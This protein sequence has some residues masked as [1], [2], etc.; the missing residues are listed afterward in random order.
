M[1]F[2]QTGI[3]LAVCSIV[4]ERRTTEDDESEET[5]E[6][7]QVD[8]EVSS[9][10]ETMSDGEEHE[11]GWSEEGQDDSYNPV[12]AEDLLTGIKKVSKI[13]AMFRRSPKLWER[14]LARTK[15]ELGKQLGL[16]FQSKTR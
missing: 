11:L 10:D 8:T 4:Y 12:F 5:E 16:K 2:P 14:L 7:E 6:Q 15:E 9:E 1:H 13:V 3:H